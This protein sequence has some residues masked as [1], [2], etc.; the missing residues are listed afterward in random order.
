M[1]LPYQRALSNMECYDVLQA[2]TPDMIS[3]IIPP[4]KKSNTYIILDNSKNIERTGEQGAHS[5]TDDCGAYKSE[6]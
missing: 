5:F 2:A 6:F 3:K 4:G 1:D